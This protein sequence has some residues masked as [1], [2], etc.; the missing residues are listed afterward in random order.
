M[1]RFYGWIRSLPDQRDLCFVPRQLDVLPHL[2]DLRPLFPAA[3]DQGQ[4]GSCVLNAIAG[5]TEYDLKKESLPDFMPSRLFMYYNT[6]V[7]EKTVKS[8]SGCA[9]R[10]AVK[11]INSLGVCDEELWP[12]KICK[13]KTKPSNSCYTSALNDRAVKY[14]AVTQSLYDMKSTLAGGYPFVIGISVYESFESDEVAKTGIVPMPGQDEG[15]MGGHGLA[16][17]GYDDS[18]QAFIVRNSWGVNWGLSGYCYIPYAY[19]TNPN[20]S[21]DFWVITLIGK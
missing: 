19:L 7:I 1:K 21:S 15:M 4:L 12:Y 16:V 20:L 9:I 18:K 5:V 11:S 13:F 3:Y 2:I 14:Q 8:D 17:A 6:R 10:D